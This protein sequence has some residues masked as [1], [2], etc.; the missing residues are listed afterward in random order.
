[1]VDETAPEPQDKTL[2]KNDEPKEKDNEPGEKKAVEENDNTS[3]ESDQN[4]DESLQKGNN[5][6]N[7]D[8]AGDTGKTD[9]AEYNTKYVVDQGLQ[10]TSDYTSTQDSIQSP[11]K[12]RYS[13]SL[14]Q[15]SLRYKLMGLEYIV[16]N[17]KD[18]AGKQYRPRL[19]IEVYE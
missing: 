16:R 7:H 17:N 9:T 15:K 19:D 18:L 4:Y 6:P 14:A 2:K 8:E 5:A 11:P 10:D 13:E 12:E 3:E 1:M